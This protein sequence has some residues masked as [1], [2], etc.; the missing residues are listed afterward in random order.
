MTARRGACRCPAAVS[1]RLS[2][3]WGCCSTWSKPDSAGISSSNAVCVQWTNQGA[4]PPICDR[5]RVQL[6]QERVDVVTSSTLRQGICHEVG[7]SVGF[8]DS[9]P[10]DPAPNGVHER[11]PERNSVRPRDLASRLLLAS[12]TIRG[13]DALRYR[14]AGVG[15]VLGVLATAC[16]GGTGLGPTTITLPPTPATTA[17]TDLAPL[18]TTLMEGFEDDI[19]FTSATELAEISDLVVIGEVGS[20][21]SAGLV[22]AE[23]DPNPSEYV[24][25][26]VKIE[27]ALKGT[28]PATVRLIWDAYLTD[29]KNRVMEIVANGLAVPKVGERFLLFIGPVSDTRK[30]LFGDLVTHDLVTLR[31]IF[32]LKQDTVSNTYIGDNPAADDLDGKSLDE[33]AVLITRETG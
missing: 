31:G 19:E 13:G 11:R 20:V 21:T 32:P 10:E 25:I 18:P 7:H 6:K 33:V 28:A 26:E 5:V 1:D 30:E 8:D 14:R 12:A 27:E 17:A 24:S 9:T 3:P 15:L 4:T 16:A 29:G 22:N 2:S 23:E